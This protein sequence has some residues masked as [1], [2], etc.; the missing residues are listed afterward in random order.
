MAQICG[1]VSKWLIV[2]ASLSLGLGLANA[3]TFQLSDYLAADGSGTV[4]GNPG[5]GSSPTE[6]ETTGNY[7]QSDGVA[8]NP[9]CSTLLTGPLF[10]PLLGCLRLI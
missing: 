6:V 7:R 8:G 2:A 4:V 3:Q 5:S 1:R 9:F 10:R